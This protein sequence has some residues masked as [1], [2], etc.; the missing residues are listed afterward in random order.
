M[1]VS[2]YR[3]VGRRIPNVTATS[4]TMQLAEPL[5]GVVVLILAVSVFP[6]V[7]RQKLCACWFLWLNSQ[8]QQLTEVIISV[9]SPMSA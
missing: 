4:H 6:L 2:E 5:Y 8:V 7:I 1:S 9:C 3:T